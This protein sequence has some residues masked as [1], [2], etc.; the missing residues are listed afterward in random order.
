MPATAPIS[1]GAY[2]RA[3]TASAR[4]A[5][6]FVVQEWLQGLM[7]MSDKRFQTAQRQRAKAMK[8]MRAKKLP[9]AGWEMLSAA[10]EAFSKARAMRGVRIDRR[11][12]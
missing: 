10:G 12:R 8:A 1:H 9:A 11:R 6:A 3:K 2:R 7:Q 5:R 4:E